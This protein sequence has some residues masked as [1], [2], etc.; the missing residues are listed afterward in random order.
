MHS[1]ADIVVIGGGLAG[2]TSAILLARQGYDVTLCEQ[3]SWPFHKVC[4]EYVSNEALG[5]LSNHQLLPSHISPSSVQKLQLS[6]ALGHQEKLQLDLG[7]FG[8][9]RFQLDHHLAQVAQ[10]EMVHLMENTKVERVQFD[11]HQDQHTVRLS[12]GGVLNCRWLI[13]SYGKFGKPDIQWKRPFLKA[14]EK[15]IGVKYHAHLSYP[16]DQI[17]LYNFEGG[18]CGVSAIEDD[19]YNICYMVSEKVFK[20]F[21]SISDFENQ[22]IRSHPV[23]GN[24]WQRARFL[25]GFPLTISQ[26]SF[27]K[28]SQIQ[29]H[30]FLIGDAAGLI[31]PL[32]GNGMAMA[33]HAAKL[34]SETFE[35]FNLP[36]TSRSQIEKA[37]ARTWRKTFVT[38]LWWGRKLQSLMGYTWSSILLLKLMRTMPGLSRRIVRLTHGKPF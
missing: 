35:K 20:R 29:D 30:V 33:F 14:K 17:G 11:Q 8:I 4:G 21:K 38:R 27:Q 25:E 24:I 37:Y 22:V 16:K 31:T 5:F 18:Y 23:L 6:D 3:K 10:K 13:G 2:L 32:C 36:D 28:R 19:R 1:S 7:G 15:F 12:D 26:I 9:S 34:L